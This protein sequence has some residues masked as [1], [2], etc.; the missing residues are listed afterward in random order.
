[1]NPHQKASLI[2]EKRRATSLEEQEKRIKEIYEKI[3]QI[4]QIDLMIKKIGFDGVNKAFNG[5]NSKENLKKIEELS[6]RKKEI[7]QENGYSKDY[8]KKK[9]FCKICNDTGFVGTKI[10]SCQ[11]QIIIDERYNQSNLKNKLN[12][13]NF[14]NFKL[15]YYG[16]NIYQSEGISPYDN[17]LQVLEVVKKYVNGFSRQTIDLYIY[18]DVGRGKTF[19][20]NSIAK[21]LMDRNFSVLYQ[22]SQRLLMFMHDYYYSF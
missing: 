10:C 2:L 14:S 19:L 6:N 7:L 20:V 8:M 3:P 15:N 17:M 12:K 5:K 18:G 11:K 21:E 16:K 1:M 9:P 13:E 22:T 4:R